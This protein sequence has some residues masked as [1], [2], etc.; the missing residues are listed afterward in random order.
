MFARG[1]LRRP[2]V[3]GGEPILVTKISDVKIPLSNPSLYKATDDGTVNIPDKYRL[4]TFLLFI[5]R[6]AFFANPE[7]DFSTKD[8]YVLRQASEISMAMDNFNPDMVNHVCILED[9][10]TA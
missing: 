7:D 5:E 8:V 4:K 10:V 2:N 1:E 9:L 6:F 3:P